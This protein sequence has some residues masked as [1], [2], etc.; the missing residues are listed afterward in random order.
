MRVVS[1]RAC[2]SHLAEPR[3]PDQLV[4]RPRTAS[5]A[6]RTT[7][8]D[9]KRTDSEQQ[10]FHVPGPRFGQRC[11]FYSAAPDRPHSCTR[12]ILRLPRPRDRRKLIPPGIVRAVRSTN[13]IRVDLLQ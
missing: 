5:T 1:L 8:A 11:S 12:D 10:S 7:Q 9:E 3:C 2:G 13:M 6:G 4:R